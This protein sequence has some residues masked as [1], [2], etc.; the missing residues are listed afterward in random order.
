MKIIDL[1]QHDETFIFFTDGDIYKIEVE[2]PWFKTN[3][4]VYKND[5]L[6]FEMVSHSF[7]N[8]EPTF[9]NVALDFKHLHNLS[10]DF[11]PLCYEDQRIRVR[12]NFPSWGTPFELF[13]NK[14]YVGKIQRGRLLLG[15]NSEYEIEINVSEEL[16]VPFFLAISMRLPTG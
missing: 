11:F 13:V 3:R 8:K 5:Q 6:I 2:N 4:L 15:S 9:Q 16:L 14:H 12:I 10:F 1:E 7:S